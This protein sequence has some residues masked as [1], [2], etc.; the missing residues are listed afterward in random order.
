MDNRMASILIETTVRQTLNGLREDSGRSVRN[1]VDMA[2]Q[3][4]EG[5]SQNRFFELAHTM[6]E[7][8]SSAYYQLIRDAAN[9][10]ETEHLVRFGMNLGY[11]SLIEGARRIRKIE[12]EKELC[13]PW[14][15]LFELDGA[16]SLEHLEQ[17]HRAIEQGERMGIYS[18]ILV[19]HGDPVPFLSLARQHPDSAFFL[20]CP[21]G[22]VCPGW[23][24]EAAE[25]TNLMLVVCFDDAAD[26]ACMQLRQAR[27]PYSVY[28][29][30]TAK[31]MEY[32]AGGELFAETQHLH[33]IFTVLIPSQDCRKEE[34][35]AIYRGII[36]TR[37]GQRYKTVPWELWYDTRRVD[38]IISDESGCVFFDIRG[39]RYGSADQT[40][41]EEGN[42]FRSS[43]VEVLQ[44]AGPQPTVPTD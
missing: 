4:S 29:P 16:R 31:D 13:I 41:S 30:Y 24:A 43:L 18:W 28:Y 26:D 38:A 12:R 39:N 42:L 15:V 21:T 34:R 14:A 25:L 22:A 1:L 20:L 40:A 17:Y 10:I 23:I 9:H 35:A 33:P 32:I 11:N 44:K 2:R 37:M 27:L 8:E 19:V 6:L 5:R 3:F 36:K 7:N